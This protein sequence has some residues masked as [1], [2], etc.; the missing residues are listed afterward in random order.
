MGDKKF[1]IAVDLEGCACVVGIPNNGLGREENYRFACAQAAR[2]ATAA[3]RALFDAGAGEVFVWDNHG[4]GVNLPY[5]ELDERCK[6]VLGNGFGKRFPGLDESFCG[7]L[8]IGYHARDNTVGSTIA[9][10]YS[11]MTY[12]SIAIDGREMG[13][14][15][16]DASV[17]GTFGV[18]LLFVSSDDKAVDQAKRSFPWIE[19]VV[20]KHSFSFNGAIS[21]HPTAA[22][23]AIYRA[24][25]KA[26]S[27]IDEM[28][29]YELHGPH[30]VKIRFKRIEEADRCQYW[31][32]DG[33]R[34][35]RTGAY[36]VEGIVRNVEDLL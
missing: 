2:E 8:L 26:V 32:A 16:I 31:G 15:E 28:K 34:F 29:P 21:L 35:T 18:P 27:R 9:H 6:I 36:T 14:M 7:I 20:T 19:S 11:S 23:D 17:A 33:K 10:T 22:C 12:Q 5:S 30:Q 25:T 4:T 3:A 13:E 1:M 24:V